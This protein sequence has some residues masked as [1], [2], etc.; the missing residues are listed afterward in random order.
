M[1]DRDKNNVKHMEQ[2][3]NIHETNHIESDAREK[4]IYERYHSGKTIIMDDLK[5]ILLK[6][7]EAFE[8]L[9]KSIAFSNSGKNFSFKPNILGDRTSTNKS[10]DSIEEDVRKRDYPEGEIISINPNTNITD[11]MTSVRSILENMSEK[12]LKDISKN[13]YEPLE[14]LKRIAVLKDLEDVPADKKVQYTYAQNNEIDI[15]M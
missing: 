6:N 9:A 11:I 4:M 14:L 7:P 3:S 5:Y 2:I 15:S 1:N 8:K 12:E 13:I 10:L